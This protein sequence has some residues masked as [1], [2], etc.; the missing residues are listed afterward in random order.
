MFSGKTN[1]IIY[2]T[3]RKLWIEE[4]SYEW[5]KDSLVQILGKLRDEGGPV[6]VKVLLG[7]ALSYVTAFKIPTKTPTR[8]EIIKEA[9]TMLP[10]KLKDENFDW[11]R[12]SL[13]KNEVYAQV[14]AVEEDF[15]NLISQAFRDAKLVVEGVA[16]AAVFVG[17][18]KVVGDKPALVYWGDRED[19]LVYS[20]KG[21]V[22]M[23][24]EGGRN[25]DEIKKLTDYI[26][27]TWDVDVS[28]RLIGLNAKNF[29]LKTTTNDWKEKGRDEDI[30]GVNL[31]K[32][33]NSEIDQGVTQVTIQESKTKTSGESMVKQI[34]KGK[35][36]A[37]L[38]SI[39]LLI[40]AIIFRTAQK[41]NT[42][43]VTPQ[44]NSIA[45]ETSIATPTEI[46]TEAPLDISML[47]VSIENASQV[48]GRAKQAASV[49]TA[50]GFATPT[51]GDSTQNLVIGTIQVKNG[52]DSRVVDKIK[53]LLNQYNFT[54][55]SSLTN[56]NQFD[57]LII[58]G[59]Q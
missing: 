16:P 13:A 43:L 24:T 37:L 56:D 25:V 20:Y 42:G 12:V 3:E 5:N 1:I 4:T 44:G 59:Q 14:I 31:L 47:K 58:I 52:V 6:N 48:S 34:G 21:V 8:E 54:V 15:L 22:L 57:V 7:N 26:K 23:A 19:M 50:A 38:G 51:V 32:K 11:K 10:I 27:V 29:S 36:W 28:K 40:G 53:N 9:Q 46:V 41:T 39:L 45:T 49:L 18:K 35:L 30:L 55:G 2:F 17:E 33:I